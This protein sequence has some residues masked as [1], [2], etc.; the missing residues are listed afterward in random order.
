MQMRGKIRVLK[1]VL[2]AVVPIVLMGVA[3]PQSWA[4]TSAAGLVQPVGNAVPAGAGSVTGGGPADCL[5]SPEPTAAGYA[6]GAECPP[7]GFPYEPVMGITKAGLRAMDP[8]GDGCSNVPDTG[9][10]FDFKDACATHDYLADLQRFG[11]KGLTEPGM[12]NQFLL[13]MKADCKGR[14]FLSRK[15]CEAVAYGY[16]AGVQEGDYSSNDANKIDDGR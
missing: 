7:E 6:S 2:T 12:D 8:Y 4:S 3:A 14:N 13:D 9:A 1:I 16:R 10:T 5:R 15:N 11:A